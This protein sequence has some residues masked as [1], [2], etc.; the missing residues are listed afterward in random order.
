MKTTVDDVF[1]ADAYK[2][3]SVVEE[4]CRGAL[5]VSANAT[6]KLFQHTRERF[7]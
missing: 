4:L 7:A 2:S 6:L 3:A 5:E 1:A